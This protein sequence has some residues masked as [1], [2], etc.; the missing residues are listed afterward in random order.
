[1]N[2]NQR[3]NSIILK[4]SFYSLFITGIFVLIAAIMMY[5]NWD[6]TN[7]IQVVL[8][9]GILIGIH[10]LLHLGY[11]IAYGYSPLETG[12]WM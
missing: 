7:R 4:P 9:L 11:E 2:R 6:M 1:M 5:Q 10:G 8:L 3:P 12:R